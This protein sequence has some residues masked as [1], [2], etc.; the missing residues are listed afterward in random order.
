M[1]RLKTSMNRITSLEELTKKD[2]PIHRM[3]P[4][5]KLLATVVYL[6]TV[7]SFQ[8]EQISG[9]IVY[10]C[11]PILL[12]AFGEIPVKPLFL[13]VLIA[14]PF[15][16]F[17]GLSNLFLN[18][19]EVILL[20]SLVITVGMLTFVSILFKTVLTV[21]AVLLL[22]ATTT[23]NDLLYAMLYF[24]IPNIL[25]MQITMTFRYLGVLMGEATVM[26]HAYI[27][28]APR[29][30][31]IQLKNMGSFLGQL[32]IR[33]FD[34]AER[35][36]HAMKCRGFE[37]EFSFSNRPVVPLVQWFY[38]I[39]LSGLLILLRYVNIS[40]LIGGFLVS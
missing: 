33:S 27:L 13:R 12:M 23:M 20:G 35:I 9:L 40:E 25:V 32:I 18:Q 15:S 28:R 4:A 30:K 19:E 16:V 3:H 22:I 38:L 7:I 34:R 36:Y 10:F 1:S 14:L 37:R 31:G 21:S 6:I 11:Y 2:T 29:E 5:I 24:H 39:V 8:G 17:A 26:Y